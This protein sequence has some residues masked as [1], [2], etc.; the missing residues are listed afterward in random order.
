MANNWVDFKA[1]K[2]AVSMQMVLDHY[3][4]NW[5]RKEKQELVGRCPIRLTGSMFAPGYRAGV[6]VALLAAQ[7]PVTLPPPILQQMEST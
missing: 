3:Q 4:I 7:V 5:L 2:N 1:I 6:V